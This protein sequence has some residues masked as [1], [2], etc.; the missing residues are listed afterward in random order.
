MND[1]ASWIPSV[2]PKIFD[3][4]DV[5]LEL[6]QRLEEIDPRVKWEA[7][8]FGDNDAYLAFSPNF[9]DEL[10]PVTETLARMIPTIH[11]WHFFGAK[12]RKRWSVRKVLLN[13]VEYFFDDWRYRL[14]MFK[15]GEFFDVDFFTFDDSIAEEAREGLGVFLAS[16]ELGEKLF[17]RAVDR[18]NVITKPQVGETSVPIGS[19]YE[20]IVD[21]FKGEMSTE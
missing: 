5:Q 15:E 1:I 11:G 6:G 16:S 12:P 17:M 3:D 19:L 9:H 4:R 7:G 13:D 10:L 14:V 18:V 21:L 20:Q 2:L 8:P